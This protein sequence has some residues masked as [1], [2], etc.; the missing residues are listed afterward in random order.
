MSIKRKRVPVKRS[1]LIPT[2]SPLA[3]DPET[4]AAEQGVKAVNNID[5]LKA[6]FWPADESIDDFH[7]AV[8]QWRQESLKRSNA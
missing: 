8:R 3:T 1:A 4:L 2:S 6:D 7:S 5:E